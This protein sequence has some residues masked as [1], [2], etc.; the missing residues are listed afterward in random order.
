[1][2]PG[3]SSLP[4]KDLRK[5][6]EA[7]LEHSEVTGE[8]DISQVEMIR[9]LRLQRIELE[10]QNKELRRSQDELEASRERYVDLYFHAPVGYIT[11]DSDA[12]IEE[13]NFRA[14]ELLGQN[15]DSLSQSS[16][17][18]HI[19][20]QSRSTLVEHLTTVLSSDGVR[21]CQLTV[22]LPTKTTVHLKM[23]SIATEDPKGGTLQCRGALFDV[24]EEKKNQICREE[25]ISQ[26]RESHRMEALGR[27]TS[28][29]AHDF[30]NLL[31]LII[32][33]SKLLINQLPEDSPFALHG[34]QIHKAGH[35]ASELIEQLLAFSRSQSVSASPVDVNEIVADMETMFDRLVG[36]DIELHLHLEEAL[37]VV[38]FASCQFQQVLMNLVVNAREAMPT[39]G[40]VIIRTRNA[41]VSSELAERF[42]IPPGPHVLIEVED[43]GTGISP[44]VIPHIFEPF[45][46]TKSSGSSHGFGLSTSYGIVRQ[47]DGAIDVVSRPDQGTTFF[48]YLPRT[49]HCDTASDSQSQPC[50]LVVDDQPDLRE[51]AALVLEDLDVEVLSARSS[52]DAL[53]KARTHGRAID[54]VVT[55]VTMPG[56]SGPELMERLHRCHPNAIVLYISG[57]DRQVVCADRGISYDT[58]FLEKPFNPEDLRE[59]VETLLEDKLDVNP[60]VV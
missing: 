4:L 39:G 1:M 44:E 42:E 19:T 57:H 21:H 54:L 26:L 33:Y 5:R 7:L 17:L 47:H 38:H 18:D 40:E 29:I 35:H 55:D 56:L 10:L 30:N 15:R 23:L 16:L 53:Q 48:V 14:S 43:S 24:T 34:A 36:D 41:E 27:L 11:L 60:D 52:T 25:L 20:P 58:P 28:G 13:L 59:M 37:G 12:T 8:E 31:T 32:G 51:Y 6:A 22:E 3:E 46:T 9:E 50:V 49:D 2:N 45:F